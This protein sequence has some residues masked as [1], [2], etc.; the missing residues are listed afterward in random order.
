M[1]DSSEPVENVKRSK[2]S[3][4]GNRDDPPSAEEV[5]YESVSSVFE[6]LNKLEV[7]HLLRGR[8]K[9]DFL[10]TEAT[11]P[12][13]FRKVVQPADLKGF[14]LA[15]TK[16]FRKPLGVP[17]HLFFEQYED[18]T[19]TRDV[20][21][22]KAGGAVCAAYEIAYGDQ[23]AVYSSFMASALEAGQIPYQ[24]QATPQRATLRAKEAGD[25]SRRRL[26]EFV[27]MLPGFEEISAEDRDILLWD[28]SLIGTWIHHMKYFCK[29]DW[30]YIFPG[31][32]QIHANNY[33]FE[34]LGVALEFVQLG[35]KFCAVFNG[36]GLTLTESYLLLAAAFFDPDTTTASNKQLLGDL[37]MLYMDALTYMIGHG[38]NAAERI[39]VYKKLEE[40]HS[41]PTTLRRM[42]RQFLSI[43]FPLLGYGA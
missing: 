34:Q 19:N 23:I 6:T 32:E 12:S 24:P 18:L 38:R 41:T 26:T 11:F 39:A 25:D 8:F 28:K 3:H 20:L 5:Q 29:G 33:C 14:D 27:H 7:E 43:A 15:A 36:I 30:Y 9:R 35:H 16:A 42:G 4:P 17:S 22:Q 13:G 40:A 31:P 37:H 10:P 1:D 2:R 21:L